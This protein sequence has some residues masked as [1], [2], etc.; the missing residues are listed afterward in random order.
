[1]P[2]S[3]N[4][5]PQ[6]REKAQL[7]ETFPP[8][9]SRSSSRS[10]PCIRCDEPLFYPSTRSGKTSMLCCSRCGARTRV[11]ALRGWMRQVV[12]VAIYIIT[13]AVVLFVCVK[14]G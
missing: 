3:S 8:P 12:T 4:L 7:H 5:E 11:P 10:V 1:M 9:R 13:L 2:P 14:K 6:P